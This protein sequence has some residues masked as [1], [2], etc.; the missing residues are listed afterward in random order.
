MKALKK[1]DTTSPI[2]TLC[3]LY[4]C[5]L[6]VASIS[7][8]NKLNHRD[9][10]I[11]PSPPPQNLYSRTERTNRLHG[12]PICSFPNQRSLKV[13]FYVSFW[14]SANACEIP[15]HCLPPFIL[16]LTNTSLPFYSCMGAKRDKEPSLFSLFFFLILCGLFLAWKAKRSPS[17]GSTENPSSLAV[18]RT[19][20]PPLSPGGWHFVPELWYKLHYYV[21]F[22]RAKHITSCKPLKIMKEVRR[23]CHD[24]SSF[25][26]HNKD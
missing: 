22:H 5:I 13:L 2:F 3:T 8:R 14:K 19:D 6:A 10:H 1:K 17:N 9:T 26:C 20:W 23:D 24:R 15:L 25:Y 21:I 18:I 7:F 11:L 12:F 4:L 16:S